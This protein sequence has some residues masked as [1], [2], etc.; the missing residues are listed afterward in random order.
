MELIGKAQLLKL[1]KKN[2]GNKDLGKAIDILIKDIKD[3]KWKNKQDVLKARPDADCVHNDGFFFLNLNV[4]RTMLL[5]AFQTE[6]NDNKEIGEVDV[7]WIG[8]H[9]DYEQ[10]FKNNKRTIEKWLRS[11]GHIE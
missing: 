3:A 10:H 7:V 6:V 11:H 5:I 4:H 2:I 8:T 1:K 9:D